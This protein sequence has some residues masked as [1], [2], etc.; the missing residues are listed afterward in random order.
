M[1]RFIVTYTSDYYSGGPS[2]GANGFIG[3]FDTLDEAVASLRDKM[4]PCSAA[5]ILD[6][7][8]R[9]VGELVESSYFASI[10][11]RKLDAK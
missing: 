2:I 4:N 8:Q 5:D 10:V 9:R 3:D 11:W 7:K 6:Q 1:K